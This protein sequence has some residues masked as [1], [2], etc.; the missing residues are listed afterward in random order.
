ME[1]IPKNKELRSFSNM[2]QNSA[3]PI[4]KDQDM[5]KDMSVTRTGSDYHSSMILSHW[6]KLTSLISTIDTAI[7][8]DGK[9]L[10]LAIVIAI[11]RYVINI[12]KY[13]N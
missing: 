3:D 13:E 11:A 1:A 4:S 10:D 7:D 8:L 12:E 9:S 2:P 6:D 5:Q